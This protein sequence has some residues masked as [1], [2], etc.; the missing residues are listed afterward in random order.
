MDLALREEEFQWRAVKGGV[1][2]LEDEC[3]LRRGSQ[4][5]GHAPCRARLRLTVGHQT[6]EARRPVAEVI[7]DEDREH[8]TPAGALQ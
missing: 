4:E 6:L 8:A 1:P 3:A 2:R 7:V 5:I